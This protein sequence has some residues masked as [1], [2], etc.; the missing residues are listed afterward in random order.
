[1]LNFVQCV[2]QKMMK[3]YI[4]SDIVEWVQ[5]GR[6]SMWIHRLCAH[7]DIKNDEYYICNYCV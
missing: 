4:S 1:M 6:C 3:V 5:C 2:S 7:L